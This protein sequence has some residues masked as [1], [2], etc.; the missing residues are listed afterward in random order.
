MPLSDSILFRYNMKFI[1]FVV[2][3]AL[4][5]AAP[6]MAQIPDAVYSP[7]IQTVQLYPSGNQLGFPV[8]KLNGGDRLELHFDD[9][10]GNVKNYSYTYQLCNADWTP[11]V[12]NQFDYIRGFLQ[13]RITNYRVS[14]IAYTRYTHYQAML[15]DQNT[16]PTRPGNYILKVFVNG[17]TSRL[18]FTKRMLVIADR[19][20]IVAQIQQPFNGQIFKTHQKIQFRVNLPDGLNVV[21]QM[22]QIKVVILQNQRWDN[23]IKDIR[24]TIFTRNTL[25]YNTENDAVFPAGKEWRW[26]DIRSFRF[27][28]DRVERANYGNRSTDIF[29]KP[30]ANRST[31][32]FNFF[33]D[34]NGLFNIE[35]SEN[36]NPLWQADYATVHF[37]YV[38]GDKAPFANRD[39]FIF[40]KLS[41]YN[42]N[43][44]AK[45]IFNSEKGVYEH[46]LFLKQGYYDYCYVTVDKN[47]PKRAASFEFTEGNYWES[48]N[49]YTILVYYRELAGRY[50]ELI[51]MANVNSLTGRQG[52][53][54]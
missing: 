14:S 46:S 13:Q 1:L 49:D 33:R 6:A 35:P 2:L 44:S 17:D 26:L 12:L 51:G 45:M 52:L 16:T 3:P 20:T 19:A 8:L 40:G 43:D 41:N 42:L 10:D 30:D 47:D 18:I 31:Q 7:H 25:E 5:Q 34:G 15:P 38:P 37:T 50:D 9:L 23:A 22:Q 54:R 32:R 27:Q 29:V 39:L 48:E 4:L 11:A 53:G 28:S 24:P 21:N 36:V